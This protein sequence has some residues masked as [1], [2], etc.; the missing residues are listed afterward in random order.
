MAKLIIESNRIHSWLTSN[1]FA[2][3]GKAYS[4]PAGSHDTDSYKM[5][6]S[7][8]THEIHVNHTTGNVTHSLNGE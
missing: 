1:G 5:K 4:G 8:G 6:S 3:Q 2:H 7:E